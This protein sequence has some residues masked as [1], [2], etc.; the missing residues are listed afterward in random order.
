MKFKAI[1]VA[2]ALGAAC[3]ASPAM[4]QVTA[5]N[6][7][8]IESALKAAGYPVT[9]QKDGSGDP[10]IKTVYE[11]VNFLI[12][13]YGCKNNADCTTVSFLTAFS[14]TKKPTLERINEWNS[15]RRFSRVYTDNEGDPVVQWEVDLDDGGMSPALF[16]DNVEWFV[17][18]ASTVRNELTK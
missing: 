1:A 18:A 3:L 7:A 2:A 6:P 16:I 12:N 15:K 5:K 14:A 8:S 10:M 17:A 4:A 13:F 11:G 9:M